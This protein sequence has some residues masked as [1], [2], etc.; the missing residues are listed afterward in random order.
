[1]IRSVGK[2]MTLCGGQSWRPRGK[3]SRSPLHGTSRTWAMSQSKYLEFPGLEARAGGRQNSVRLEADLSFCK[4]H[5]RVPS[6]MER[7]DRV[8]GLCW[9]NHMR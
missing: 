7:E 2:Y 5:A 8:S 1:M 3:R 9:A 4:D 6:Q